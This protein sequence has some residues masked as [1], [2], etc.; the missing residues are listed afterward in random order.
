M[1]VF[2]RIF[3]DLTTLSLRLTPYTELRDLKPDH[4]LRGPSV[5]RYLGG[6]MAMILRHHIYY[7]PP[8]DTDLSADVIPWLINDRLARGSQ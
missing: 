1:L 5:P 4:L 6:V 8:S 3:E 7:T 2:S